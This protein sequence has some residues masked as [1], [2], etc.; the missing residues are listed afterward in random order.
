MIR[1]ITSSVFITVLW[2]HGNVT[3]SQRLPVPQHLPVR[4]QLAQARPAQVQVRQVPVQVRQQQLA[5]AHQQQLAQQQHYD[6]S[7]SRTR[8]NHI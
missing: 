6:N 5:Q 3:H 1:Q 8:G 4:H 2:L 7:K